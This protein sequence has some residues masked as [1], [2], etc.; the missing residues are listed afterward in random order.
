MACIRKN[1]RT[2]NVQVILAV[3]VV[4]TAVVAALMSSYVP[5]TLRI[6]VR[7]SLTLKIATPIKAVAVMV[8]TVETVATAVK[9]QSANRTKPS[10]KAA[11]SKS[12]RKAKPMMLIVRQR[13]SIRA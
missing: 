2:V 1:I 11:A 8:E 12:V 10:S 9:N 5:L 3:P 4:V 13:D 6:R 7:R